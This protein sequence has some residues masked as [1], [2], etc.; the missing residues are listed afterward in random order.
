MSGRDNADDRP[1]QAVRPGRTAW[2]L[3]VNAEDPDGEK[4]TVVVPN[5]T[6][7]LGGADTMGKADSRNTKPA[8]DPVDD[9]EDADRTR[10]YVAGGERA[11]DLSEMPVG[12]LVVVSG[13]GFGQSFPLFYGS[14]RIG[15][16]ANVEVPLNFGDE[17]ISRGAHARVTYDSRGRQFYVQPGEGTGLTYSE[18]KPILTP[19]VLVAEM[20]IEIGRTVL[21]FLPLCNE[22]FDWQDLPQAKGSAQ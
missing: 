6:K 18:G 2:G 4:P 19:T 1:T 5:L 17:S 15:R 10:I 20:Q 16:G 3:G 22:T 11:M 14:N 8:T 9:D 13:S 7:P 12:W 21:R